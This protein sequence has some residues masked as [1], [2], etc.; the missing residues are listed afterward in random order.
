MSK[1]LLFQFFHD[2]KYLFI[3][4]ILILLFIITYSPHHNESFDEKI[5]NS[6]TDQCG[7]ICSKTYDCNGFAVDPDKNICYLSKKPLL[8]T[9][10]ESKYY[11]DFNN[12]FPI[13]NKVFSVYDASIASQSDL[14]ENA[15]YICLDN[16]KSNNRNY[17]MFVNDKQ[18]INSIDRNYLD[19]LPDVNYTFNDIQWG[20]TL[21]LNDNMYLATNPT[22]DNSVTYFTKSNIKRDGE[23]LYSNKN[24]ANISEKDCL[25]NCLSDKN[26]VAVD[27]NP[28]LLIKN[29]DKFDNYNSVCS[30]YKNLHGETIRNDNEKLGNLYVK[31][32]STD[33]INNIIISL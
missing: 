20:N 7:V 4:L 5:T 15:S 25:G 12:S 11:Q 17:Y 13:C 9:P 32:V 26:C 18:K 28:L 30:S 22:P 19:S 24:V 1:Y 6:T 21:N 16:I 2:Y 23:P 33:P 27:W 10:Y 29:G 31:N 3:I 8:G 14:K